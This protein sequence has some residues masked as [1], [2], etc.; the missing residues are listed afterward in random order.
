MISP[1]FMIT[2]AKMQGIDYLYDVNHDGVIDMNDV[3]KLKLAQ[4]ATDYHIKAW[5]ENKGNV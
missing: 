3:M 1:D 4:G 2:Y 5:N